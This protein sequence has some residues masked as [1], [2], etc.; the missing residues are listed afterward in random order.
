ME[1]RKSFDALA[2]YPAGDVDTEWDAAK[3]VLIETSKTVL[4]YKNPLKKEWMSEET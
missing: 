1:L 2:V 3:G 4:G